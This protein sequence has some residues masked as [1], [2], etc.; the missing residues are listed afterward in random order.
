MIIRIPRFMVRAWD[1]F[2]DW[3]N[4]VIWQSDRA[5]GTC[6]ASTCS[7]RAASC[8]VSATTGSS[9]AGIGALQGA[10]VY[11]FVSMCAL[12]FFRSDRE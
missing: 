3:S 5:A 2:G 12:W 9:L 7:S 6:P 10:A 11:I 8:S 1:R 4:V